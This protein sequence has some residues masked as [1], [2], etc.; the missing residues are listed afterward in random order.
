MRQSPCCPLL[1]T[2]LPLLAACGG[3]AAWDA[4]D[5][6]PAAPPQRIV[7]GSILATEV[8][9]ELAPRERLA[10]VHELAAN[11]RF[12]LTAAAVHGLPTC[13]AAPE[14]LLAARPDLVIVD[15]FTRAETLALL[16]HA[17]VPVVRT[18]D[19]ASFADVAANVR[20]IGRVCHLDD[21][22]ERLV[23]RMEQGLAA[24]RA[25]ANAF[26]DWR[27]LS[28]D[29]AL[30][31]YGRG[32]LPDAVLAAAGVQNLAAAHGVGAFRR[33]DAET[34]LAWRPDAIVVE[35]PADAEQHAGE[36]LRQH[37]GL[38][39]LPCVQQGRIVAIPGPLLSTTSH[40]VVGAAEFVQATLR[41]WGRP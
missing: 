11:P 13:A 10:A 41:R 39:L 3:A 34:V 6:R 24:V 29:G 40:H 16:R 27:V 28:L 19:A 12:A 33:L 17:E 36:W 25:E 18:A 32:S 35:A 21:A 5:W 14:R 22:A 2:A 23:A 37:P 8:L 38:R 30:H 31:S 9:L 1:L 4:P 26:A 15:A 20:R 7:A